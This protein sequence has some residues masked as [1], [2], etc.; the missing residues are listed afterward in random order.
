MAD[1]GC[2]FRQ[3]HNLTQWL[4]HT[5]ARQVSDLPARSRQY[6]WVSDLLAV[7]DRRD[8]KR[9]ST[10]SPRLAAHRH[11]RAIA[12]RVLVP[13]LKWARRDS[14][15]LSLPK[16][17]LI[18]RRTIDRRHPGAEETQINRHLSAVMRQVQQRVLN[19]FM[20]WRFSYHLAAGLQLPVCS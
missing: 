2:K 9:C 18:R 1:A 15:T 8:R 11:G 10:A 4:S 16:L 6:P 20:S 3:R 13:E 19:H 17:F 12:E 14:E 5:D 7:V